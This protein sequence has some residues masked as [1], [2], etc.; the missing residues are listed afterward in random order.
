MP[1][2]LQMLFLPLMTSLSY[3]NLRHDSRVLVC[4]SL[5]PVMTDFRKTVETGVDPR[6]TRDPF[7]KGMLN[8]QQGFTSTVFI[9]LTA[10]GAY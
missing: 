4:T 2:V 8:L 7:S 9:R 5:S 1:V 3:K 10:L 6:L